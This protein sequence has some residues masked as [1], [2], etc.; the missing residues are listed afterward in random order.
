MSH[1]P[2]GF[3]V[4]VTVL[5]SE[6]VITIVSPASPVPSMPSLLFSVTIGNLG[7][8]TTVSSLLFSPLLAEIIAAPPTAVPPATQGNKTPGLNSSYNNGSTLS[9][10]LYSTTFRI[11]PLSFVN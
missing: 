1:V 7:A 11:P 9:K 5:P 3:T 10:K 6:S 8:M 2:S 4:V